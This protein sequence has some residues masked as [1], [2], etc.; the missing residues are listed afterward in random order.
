MSDK[1]IVEKCSESWDEEF[2]KGVKNRNN[3]SGFV[4]SVASKLGVAIVNDNAD[5]IVT[6]LS[7]SSAWKNLESGTEAAT[8]ARRGCL[9]IAGL[10]AADHKPS[11]NNGH[12]VV[13]V[14]GELYRVKYPKCWSGSTG[15]AQSQG[16][17]SVGEVWAR[18]DRDNVFYFG[19]NTPV[20]SS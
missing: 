15:G 6:A 17:K 9:V 11:R 8:W 18:T 5:G 12:V 7:E 14:D 10:K 20:C 3:C 16:T 1:C 4:K 19:Y 2:L 13:V